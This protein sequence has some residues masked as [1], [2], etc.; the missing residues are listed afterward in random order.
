MKVLLIGATGFVGQHVLMELLHRGHEITAVSRHANS[1]PQGLQSNPLLHIIQVDA[2]EKTALA[3]LLIGQDAVISAFSVG[4]TH[5]EFYE[6]FM[7][8]STSIQQ[9]IAQSKVK[10][11]IVVGGAGSL[12][13]EDG[14]QL[15]DSPDFPKS[16]FAGA[17]AARDYLNILSQNKSLDWTFVSP[18]VEMNKTTSGIRKG[19]YRT[20][21]DHPVVDQQGRS[22][23]S[24][25]DLAMAIV[26][27]L[28]NPQFIRRRFTVAY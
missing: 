9:T 17:S 8:G 11:L 1:L 16:L 27:E 13:G 25:E 20:G 6:A 10:R 7:A 15:V 24:V 26:D 2:A 23:I 28:E 4:W 22:R 5:P 18:A 21:L 19:L 12:L 14:G 3:P